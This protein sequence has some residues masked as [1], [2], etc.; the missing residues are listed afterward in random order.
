MTSSNLTPAWA[1]LQEIA[2]ILERGDSLE[3]TIAAIVGAR[4]VF[5]APPSGSG[6]SPEQIL[7]RFLAALLS[8]FSWERFGLD[9]KNGAQ[10]AAR[11]RHEIR[12]EPAEPRSSGAPLTRDEIAALRI[13]AETAPP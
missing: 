5:P 2:A 10:V 6:E 12:G 9:A 7:G 4:R 3:E 8:A 11:L 1:E 13:L